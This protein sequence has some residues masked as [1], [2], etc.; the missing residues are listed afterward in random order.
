MSDRTLIDLQRAAAR[1]GLDV[2]V[3]GGR[4]VVTLAGSQARLYRNRRPAFVREFVD[5]FRGRGR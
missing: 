3:A 1:R 4:F 2:S 5:S